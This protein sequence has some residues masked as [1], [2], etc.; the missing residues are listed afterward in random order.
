A[1]RRL[2]EQRVVHRLHEVRAQLHRREQDLGGEGDRARVVAHASWVV[3]GAEHPT[4]R[5]AHDVGKPRGGA[6]SRSEVLR[7]EWSRLRGAFAATP[8]FRPP[9]SISCSALQRPM[10]RRPSPSTKSC[11]VVPMMRH[12]AIPTVFALV[13]TL[14]AQPPQE[15]KAKIQELK[16][17]VD[18]LTEK[19]LDERARLLLN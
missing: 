11:R 15:D 1:E 12:F 7:G 4:R 3:P 9:P 14:S 6:A 13:A 2:P 17:S 10:S 16:R 19:I 8:R 5:S 18:R